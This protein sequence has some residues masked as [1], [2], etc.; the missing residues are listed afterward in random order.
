MSDAAP[1]C[2][3][4][5]N[6]S[7]LTPTAPRRLCRACGDG[8][9]SSRPSLYCSAAC[10][11]R[12]FRQRQPKAFPDLGAPPAPTTALPVL[13]ECGG[14]GEQFLDGRRRED[15]NR[16]TRRLGLAVECPHCT[17][18]ILIEDLLAPYLKEAAGH[19]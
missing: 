8:Y 11:I 2:N 5:G 7:A 12:A 6:A 17:E 4:S 15:C 1:L 9:H 13:Y 16:F 19:P 10:R 3:A 14:C 18:P